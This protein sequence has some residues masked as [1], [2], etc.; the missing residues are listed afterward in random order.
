MCGELERLVSWEGERARWMLGIGLMESTE[1]EVGDRVESDD[2]ERGEEVVV[3]FGCWP[4]RRF[5][6]G[7]DG[8]LVGGL[9]A[10]AAASGVVSQYFRNCD[11]ENNFLLC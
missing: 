11:D 2:G 1:A 6:L 10:G 8:F 9:D 3:S 4:R 7:L 5:I